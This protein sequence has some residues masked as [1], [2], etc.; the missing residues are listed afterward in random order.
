MDDL[1]R[2]VEEIE[3]LS[4]IY[5]NEW[6]TVSEHSRKYELVLCK[7]TQFEMH[8]HITLPDSYP[9]S[10]TPFFEVFAPWLKAED[11]K[12]LNENLSEIARDN[13]G[14]CILF[15]WTEAVRQF[16]ENKQ[17]DTRVVTCADDPLPVASRVESPAFDPAPKISHGEPFVD[18]KSTFQ[19]HLAKATNLKEVNAVRSVLLENRKIANATHNIMAYR[20]SN[21]ATSGF[22][23]DCDDDGE[24]AAGG[25]LLHLLEIVG[26]KD[27]VVVVSRWY[28]G[29][30]LGPDRFKHINNVARK[31]LLQ[32]NFIGSSAKKTK[33]GKWPCEPVASLVPNS[34]N[35]GFGQRNEWMRTFTA[36]SNLAIGTFHWGCYA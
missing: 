4:S 30:Q 25:R 6:Q 22:L 17:E 26:A 7:G 28:G 12:C 2:Q 8:F 5:E 31:L 33:N 15:L 9:S 14:E 29:I 34:E 13:N 11:R 27:V 20:I 23:Q 1:S 10:E 18:R 16:V 35:L 36:L 24:S 19:A 3:A 32:E 21:E